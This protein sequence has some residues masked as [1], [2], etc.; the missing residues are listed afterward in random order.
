ME[1]W[2]RSK[3]NDFLI[4]NGRNEWIEHVVAR[5]KDILECP[6]FAIEGSIENEGTIGEL[7]E[8]ICENAKG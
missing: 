8:I 6:H 3:E 5:H 4:E 2:E 1:H 7:A